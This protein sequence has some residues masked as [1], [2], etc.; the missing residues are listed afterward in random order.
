M[1]FII[2]KSTGQVLSFF[3]HCWRHPGPNM[4]S[5]V[6]GVLGPCVVTMKCKLDT[7][8]SPIHYCCPLILFKRNVRL[9]HK[10]NKS[11]PPQ[12]RLSLRSNPCTPTD[13]SG[14]TPAKLGFPLAMGII[15][16]GFLSGSKRVLSLP[17]RQASGSLS[18]ST[19]IIGHSLF[20]FSCRLQ[21]PSS[22]SH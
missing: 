21:R 5:Q 10:Y 9:H 2:S 17:R 19:L 7:F 16:L 22:M 8:Q 1:E 13:G 4:C 6:S 3:D 15:S 20:L 14:K 11:L 12:H 18:L